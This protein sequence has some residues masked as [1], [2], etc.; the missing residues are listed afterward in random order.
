P[1]YKNIADIGCGYGRLLPSYND[2]DKKIT[3]IDPSNDLLEK[4][5]D[6]YFDLDNV[7]YK[8]SSVQKL[9]KIKP[10]SF[11][12]VLMIRV[13]HHVEDL[14]E[15]FSNLNRILK[16]NGYLILEFANKMHGKDQIKNMLSG[17]FTFP[18]DI[19]PTDKRS[20]KNIKNDSISFLNHHPDIVIETL[21]DKKF[22]ILDMRSVSNF[23]H[24]IFK[25]NLSINN[26]MIFE[27]LVQ[28]P[29]ASFHF[30]PSMF[31]LCKKV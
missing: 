24:N 22:S 12:L 14:D 15:A 4:A 25:K 6:L 2:D 11:D 19:F 28:R 29:F 21:K 31:V 16:P 10:R 7:S 3:L 18:L 27:K 30:G 20:D 26:L 23:R 5:K 17:N 8:C 13:L 1:E 9:K